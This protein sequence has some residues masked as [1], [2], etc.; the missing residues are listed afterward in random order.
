MI[1]KK[2]VTIK[3]VAAE[4]GVSYQTVSRVINNSNRVTDETRQK[5]TEVIEA[6]NF[7]PSLAARN[8][9]S[10]LTNI[11]GLIIPYSADYLIRDPH[12]L[13]QISGIDAE[14]S[15]NDYN[16]LLS[17]AGNSASGMKAFNRFLTQKIADGAIVVE[18]ADSTT[19]N[20][21]LAKQDDPYIVIGYDI[22]N[23][24]GYMVHS[25]DRQGAKEATLHLI[26]RGHQRIGLINGP[27]SGAIRSTD[28]RLLG[29]KIAL[30]SAGLSFETELVVRGD[31]TRPSGQHATKQL[32]A[33]DTPPTA[34]FALNDRMAIGAIQT[35]QTHG[36][37][38]PQ[39]I[40][41]VGFD[42][43]PA[44][45]DFIPS[46]TTVSQ[47]SRA[48]GRTAAQILLKLIAGKPVKDHEVILPAKL[49]IRQ[50]S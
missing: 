10:Q 18:T 33:L 47:P 36:L 6:L 3:D 35:I 24:N 4:A 25:D 34:I 41:V 42:D 40:V 16:L 28:E 30:E 43:I 32:L 31:Y 44:A 20:D 48:L 13:A 49:I 15:A 2:R 9:S 46:L 45:A 21:L 26:E 12:L 39:D 5:V 11:I 22:Y 8:L 50:S 7:R 1:T 19:G 23:K 27:A 29:Y 14:C 17:T 37:T 38:V